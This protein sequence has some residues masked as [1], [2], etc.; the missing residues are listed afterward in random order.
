MGGVADGRAA[1]DEVGCKGRPAHLSAT[2]HI[3]QET[4]G[5]QGVKTFLDISLNISQ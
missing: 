3:P 2:P 4:T 5:T 1:R